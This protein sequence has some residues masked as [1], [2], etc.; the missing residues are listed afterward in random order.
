M[1]GE[2]RLMGIEVNPV[3]TKWA[4]E[5]T[6]MPFPDSP[7]L[8]NWWNDSQEC[9]TLRRD[10]GK[11]KIHVAYVPWSNRL[12]CHH[13]ILVS[14]LR[15]IAEWMPYPIYG[16]PGFGSDRSACLTCKRNTPTLPWDGLL[17]PN[18]PPPRE[19]EDAAVIADWWE[20]F[21]INKSNLIRSWVMTPEEIKAQRLDYLRSRVPYP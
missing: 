8:D 5:I 20:E 11:G 17:P 4:E 9:W 3:G 14:G 21:D 13:S 19:R 15:L 10:D 18:F 7:F 12:H 1:D 6:V 16:P 2:L